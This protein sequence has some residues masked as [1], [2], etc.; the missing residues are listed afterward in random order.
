MTKTARMNACTIM[1]DWTPMRSRCPVDVIDQEPG[2]PGGEQEAGIWPARVM[3]P[4]QAAEE[5]V[6]CTT[7]R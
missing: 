5:S 2:R 6:I 4:D 3:R 1:T 7:N